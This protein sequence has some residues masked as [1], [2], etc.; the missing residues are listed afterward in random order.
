MRTK[1]PNNDKIIRSTSKQK[2]DDALVEFIKI[3]VSNKYGFTT[4]DCTSKIRKRDNV[5]F[6]HICMYMIYKNTNLSLA[7]VGKHFT[8]DHSTVVHSN[9]VIN[10][11]LFWDKK[12]KED[13]AELQQTITAKCQTMNFDL[14]EEFY[15]VELNEI[16]SIKLTNNKSLVLSGFTP[17]QLGYIANKLFT[18]EEFLKMGEFLETRN[19][20]N[21]GMYILESR[22]NSVANSHERSADG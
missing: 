14:H 22:K 19:H 2:Q 5:M 20:K 17:Q 16:D 18:D 11:H 1:N 13:L 4:H 7:S 8:V 21:T 6:R 9:K 10:N 12:L 15:Y 3:L